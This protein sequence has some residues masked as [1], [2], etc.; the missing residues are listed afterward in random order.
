M[1]KSRQQTRQYIIVGVSGIKTAQYTNDGRNLLNKSSKKAP[2]QTVPQYNHY[3]YIE[4]IHNL[5]P[6]L[7]P[8]G[9]GIWIDR[10]NGLN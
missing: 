6:L 5:V 3:Q 4:R 7:S 9:A 8:V 2:H 10:I 1:Y